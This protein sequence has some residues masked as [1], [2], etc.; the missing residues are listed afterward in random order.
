MRKSSPVKEK[1][2]NDVV[3]RNR[4]QIVPILPLA[5]KED[6]RVFRKITWR[7]MPVLTCGYILNYLDRNNIGFAALTMNREIGLSS[8]AFGTAAGIFFLGYCFLE[9]PSNIVLYRVGARLW[10]A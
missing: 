6:A 1:A 3:R 9:L 8:T 4:S 7:I 10:L 2:V 5:E